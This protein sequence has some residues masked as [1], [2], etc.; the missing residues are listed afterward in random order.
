MNSTNLEDDF[1]TEIKKEIDSKVAEATA[2]LKEAVKLASLLPRRTDYNN[3]I[4]TQTLRNLEDAGELSS[5]YDLT[6]AINEAGWRSS[7]LSC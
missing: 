4:Y 6:D 1:E 2:A 3:R 7:S 5:W